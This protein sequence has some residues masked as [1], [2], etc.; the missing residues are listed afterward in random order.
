MICFGRKGSKV[1]KP[2][3]ARRPK[4]ETDRLEKRE[5]EEISESKISVYG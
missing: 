4:E 2:P 1:E 5:P 3:K